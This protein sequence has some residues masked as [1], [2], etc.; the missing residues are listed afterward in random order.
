[1]PNL[2]S[3]APSSDPTRLVVGTIEK[4]MDY[5]GFIRTQSSGSVHMDR[6]SLVRPG[7]WRNL[8]E[9]QEV[10]FLVVQ[11]E[12]GPHALELQLFSEPSASQ[13]G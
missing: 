7:A 6:S 13:Q 11:Q 3:D 4:M 12:K 1:M 10:V 9:G 2:K 5:F 8:K